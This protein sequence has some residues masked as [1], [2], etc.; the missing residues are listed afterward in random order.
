MSSNPGSPV[1]SRRRFLGWSQAVLAAVGATGFFASR[2][3]GFAEVENA[4]SADDYYEKLGVERINNAAE[5]ATALTGALMPA[6]VQRAVARAALHPVV[7]N[8]LQNASGKYIARRLRCEGAM[9]TSGAAGAL[10][11]ATAACIAAANGIKPEQIP[12]Q[13]VAMKCE[14]IVQKAHRYEFEHA[15]QLCG[16]RIVEVV[17]VDDYKRAFT[18]RTVMT[19]FYNAAEGGEIDRQAWLD[20]A[21]QHDI[22]CHM[23]AAGD[24]P[25]IENL[26]KYTGMGYD[27]VCFSGGKGIRGSQNTGLLLGRKRLTDLAAAND[28]PNSEAVGR[29]MKV[30]KEQI[31]GMVAALDWFLEQNEEAD[32]AEYVWRVDTIVRAVKNIP[33]MKVD[34][35]TPEFANHAPHAMLTYDPKVIGITPKQVQERL[36]AMQ[37]RIELNGASGST[38]PFGPHSNENTLVVAT[39]MMQPGDAEIVGRHL[40]EV[41][42]HPTLTLGN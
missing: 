20:I 29:G 9:V 36:R 1:L 8:D 12:E 4:A 25:P 6:Q 28:N 18:P 13:V 15:M 7:L 5:P 40:H 41:L 3:Q 38:I 32:Q 16:V 30:A 31:V 33:T 14:V 39:W 10:T 27:L 34:I 11:L 37:P 26:W 23:D 42:S 21:H 35:F 2:P 19:N 17:T 24:L 22:P